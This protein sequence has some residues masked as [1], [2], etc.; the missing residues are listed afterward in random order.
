MKE[1][2]TVPY[3][4]DTTE[5]SILLFDS[6]PLPNYPEKLSDAHERYFSALNKLADEHWPKT[7]LLVSHE[8]CVRQAV[9]WGG[10]KDNVEASYCGQVELTRK[11]QG[12][13]DW[14]LEGF[15]RVYKYDVPF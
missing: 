1:Q 2:P 14:K 10:S 9:I 11:Q 7:L 4:E 5:L 3:I 6:S 13:Y 12:T 15:D 8:I